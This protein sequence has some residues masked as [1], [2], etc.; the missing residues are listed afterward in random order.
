MVLQQLLSNRRLI[1]DLGAN[2]IGSFYIPNP[3]SGN[4]PRFETGTKTFTVIDNA[5]NDQENTDT[6]GED[7][8]TAAGTLETV[9]E[10]IISTRNAI[11][12]TNLLKMKDQLEH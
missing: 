3:N 6:F 1:S 12:Q 7:N 4:H 9:Q 10:N 8:Y 5:T 11:I 2:L